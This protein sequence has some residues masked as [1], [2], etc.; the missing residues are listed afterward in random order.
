M[1]GERLIAD[2]TLNIPHPYEDG[3]AEQWIETHE[4]EYEAE[5]LATF[6]IV[7][8]ERKQ[9]IGAIGLRIEPDQCQTPGAKPFFGSGH[10]ESWNASRG[11]G[12]AGNDPEQKEERPT[13]RAGPSMLVTIECS[14]PLAVLVTEKVERITRDSDA[15][16]LALRS[17]AK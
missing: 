1:L 3:M 17:P 9:L 14:L 13:H 8:R 5:T 11:N 10:G 2:T 16:A 4:P 6:A 12:A 15:L 7:L